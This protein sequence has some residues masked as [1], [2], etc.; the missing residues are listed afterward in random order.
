[1]A[2]KAVNDTASLDGLV[3]I[4]LVY[5]A[6]PWISNLDPFAPSVID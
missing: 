1:M 2:V 4:L 5:G 3:P 6:Y